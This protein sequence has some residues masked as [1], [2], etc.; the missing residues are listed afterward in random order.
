MTTVVVPAVWVMVVGVQDDLLLL[1]PRQVFFDFFDYGLQFLVIQVP[2]FPFRALGSYHSP[3]EP[4]HDDDDN[5]NTKILGQLSSRADLMQYPVVCFVKTGGV[6]GRRLAS[7]VS[8][9][10]CL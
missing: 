5:S 6:C 10:F 8:L 2:I 1:Q 9:V 3:T 4:D 7:S